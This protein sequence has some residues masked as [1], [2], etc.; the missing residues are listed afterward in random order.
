MHLN[1]SYFAEIILSG[2]FA[3]AT[4]ANKKIPLT[5]RAWFFVIYLSNPDFVF[6]KIPIGL[7]LLI[8]SDNSEDRRE[9]FLKR[10]LDIGFVFTLEISQ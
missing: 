4:P 2:V 7:E 9:R 6:S 3:V 1:L 5:K 8:L 10:I